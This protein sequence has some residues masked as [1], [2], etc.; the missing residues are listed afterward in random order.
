[1]LST[2]V[3]CRFVGLHIGTHF[4]PYFCLH[5][6]LSLKLFASFLFILA[7]KK[8]SQ[9][10]LLGEKKRIRIL[11]IEHRSLSLF[12]YQSFITHLSYSVHMLLHPKN[13]Q[14]SR[15]S[16]ES[17]SRYFARNA[18][19]FNDLFTNPFGRLAVWASRPP[20]RDLHAPLVQLWW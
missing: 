2:M 19:P 13:F 12:L 4:I 3:S 15:T 16:R 1:M 17:K 8:G 18:A 20:S 11:F 14:F 10:P 7:D 6:Y 9:I 5:I